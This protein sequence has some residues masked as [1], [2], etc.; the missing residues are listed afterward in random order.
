LGELNYY[1]TMSTR[2]H[3][4]NYQPCLADESWSTQGLC[5]VCMAAYP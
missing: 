4:F 3:K 1:N 2:R 5:R